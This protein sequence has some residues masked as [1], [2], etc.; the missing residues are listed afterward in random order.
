[1]VLIGMIILSLWL[2]YASAYLINYMRFLNLDVVTFLDHYS[3]DEFY[4]K[5]LGLKNLKKIPSI[6]QIPNLACKDINPKTHS[7][8]CD[9]GG[10]FGQYQLN[11]CDT[12]YN[13]GEYNQFVISEEVLN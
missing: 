5:N 7:L 9:G 2:R 6:S 13:S 8:L 11:L 1:M 12:C 10:K 3:T 4:K